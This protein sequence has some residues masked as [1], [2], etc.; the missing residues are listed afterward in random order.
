MNQPLSATRT[1]FA[2]IR[3]SV[4]VAA[5]LI[6]VIVSPGCGTSNT[7]VS[8]SDDDS[9]AADTTDDVGTL[10]DVVGAD[11]SG[12]ADVSSPD[13][14]DASLD[15]D[16]SFDAGADAKLVTDAKGET[17][18]K[19]TYVSL[20]AAAAFVVLAGETVTNTGFT[21]VNGN[22]G[23]SPGAAITGFPPGKVSGVVHL[24]NAE[25]AAGKKALNDA[26][27]DAA[28]RSGAPVP[29]SGDLGGRTLTPGLYVSATS[30]AIDSGDLTLNAGG[31][32][33]AIW[34]F[35]IGTTFVSFVGRKVILAGNARADNVFWNVGSSATIG[36]KSLM[37]GNFLT[38]TSITVQT[39]ATMEGRFL[40]QTGAVTFDSN[41]IN[42]PKPVH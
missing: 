5:L 13:V 36:V 33:D 37:V 3:S 1:A 9:G 31:D 41:N 25:A 32:E 26:Y 7:S 22:L 8:A 17:D 6:G 14:T 4:A 34:V 23:I 2:R 40:T 21:V 28:S 29:I 30:L 15:A 24:A 12:A 18:A 42:K 19:T 20:G 39:G 10:D 11:D 38:E 27:K 16:A 35:Q